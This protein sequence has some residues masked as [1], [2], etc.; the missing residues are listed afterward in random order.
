VLGCPGRL[1]SRP[2]VGAHHRVRENDC[3]GG[4]VEPYLSWADSHGVSYLGWTWETWDCGA[5]P[6][7]ITS[8]D[9]TPTAYGAVV[10]AHY[11]N[12]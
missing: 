7:V 4:Y 11:L 10:R 2:G 9:G 5:G 12:R 6:A 3:A 8:Y 1:G